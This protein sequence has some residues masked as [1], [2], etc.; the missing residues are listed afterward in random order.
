MN[1]RKPFIVI[2]F[3]G[4]SWAANSALATFHF[5]QIEQVIGGVEGDVTAQ[6]IQLRL[7]DAG[8]HVVNQS[9]IR[10]WDANGANP[11]VLRNLNFPVLSGAP[12]RRILLVTESFLSTTSP[13]TV[14]NFSMIPIPQ[15]YL[16][17][18]SLTYES[19][20]GEIVWRVSWGGAAYT[21][22]NH[23]DEIANDPDGDFGPPFSG[24]LP[25]TGCQ[26]LQFQGLFSAQSSTNLSDY[27][28]TVGP[29]V[30]MNNGEQSFALPNCI[31]SVSEW[32]IV[33]LSITLMTAG[34]L[35]L[36]KRGRSQTN[37]ST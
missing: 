2:V 20:A 17:A 21:G 18:G 7:R 37:V 12:G 23:G 14:P 19:D 6:A 5:M 28:I 32:G 34:T 3:L 25:Y 29:A 1:V 30:W 10:A 9:R 22:S 31:P 26:A 11:V 35:L 13:A 33:L 24:A 4:V 8:Q 16:V 15:S 36:G 27:A